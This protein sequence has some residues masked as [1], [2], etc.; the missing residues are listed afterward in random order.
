MPTPSRTPAGCVARYRDG[1]GADH[2]VIVRR[3]TDGAWEVLDRGPDSEQL[4][5]RLTGFDEGQPA[6]EALARD[7]A[8]YH[9][10]A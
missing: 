6:A 10:E 3:G 9:G 1:A 5:E 8:L 7:Y 4:I 2:E